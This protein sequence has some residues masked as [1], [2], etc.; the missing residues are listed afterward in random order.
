MSVHPVET[1]RVELGDRSYDILV[2]AGLIEGA[3]PLI[4]PRLRRPRAIVVT[5][6]TVARFH[7]APLQA[8]LEAAGIRCD[9]VVV[10]PGEATK[11]FDRLSGVLDAI[12]DAGIDRDSTVIALGGGVVGDLAGFAASIV[13]RGIGFIQVPTTLLSQVDSSVGGKTGINTRHGKNLI[14]TFYQPGLVLADTGVLSTLPRR[15]RLAGYAEVV[16]YGLIDDPAF[17]EWLETNG[18]AVVD[19]DPAAMRRA[20]VT[21]CR[22]KAAIVARDEHE[23]GDR[24]LLNLG[25]TF[26]HAF[27]AEAGYGGDLLHGEAVSLGMVLAF[28]MS[29]RLGLC[30]GQDAVRV[31]RHLESVGLPVRPPAGHSVEALLRRMQKD[32]KARGGRVTFILARGIGRSFVARDVDLAAVEALLVDAMA[33]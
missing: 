14:G 5:D 23:T 25:H 13:L 27:E 1:V 10:P 2:G 28:D 8:S 6:E 24:Q 33:A 22:A 3:G 20:V 31:R 17:F 26:G 7:L 29:V 15:E 21:S 9:S 16:K 4:A 32:K 11:A 12:L 19:C 18:P 30:S